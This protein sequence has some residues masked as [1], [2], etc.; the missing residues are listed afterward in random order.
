[1]CTVH[2]KLTSDQFRMIK[3][4]IGE[5][6]DIAEWLQQQIEAILQQMVMASEKEKG[7]M[8]AEEIKR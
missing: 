1:M 2:I 8:T 4:I 3:A 5:D 6:A 7:E